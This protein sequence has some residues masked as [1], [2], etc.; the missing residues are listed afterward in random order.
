MLAGGRPP[1]WNEAGLD[2][3]L[4]AT[5]AIAASPPV[6]R[7]HRAD[8]SS[9]MTLAKNPIGK[10]KFSFWLYSTWTTQVLDDPELEIEIATFL[11]PLPLNLTIT[12][13]LTALAYS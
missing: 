8:E 6:D 13:A 4:H 11:E 7:P 5:T 1:S 12:I 10:S 9:T 2:P 3:D